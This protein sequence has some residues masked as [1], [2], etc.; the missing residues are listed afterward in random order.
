MNAQAESVNEFAVTLDRSELVK[1]LDIVSGALES[2]TTMPVLGCVCI[3]SD[4]ST[5]TLTVTDIEIFIRY[6]IAVNGPSLGVGSMVVEAKRLTD[7][8]KLLSTPSVT[9]KLLPNYY[10]NVTAGKSRTKIPGYQLSAFPEMPDP[11]VDKWVSVDPQEMALAIHMSLFACPKKDSVNYVNG[12]MISLEDRPHIV[13]LDGHRMS[14]RRFACEGGAG[15]FLMH[16]RALGEVKRLLD[17]CSGVDI[18]IAERYMRIRSEVF[19]VL[20]KRMENSYLDYMKIVELP[21]DKSCTVDGGELAGALRR[22]L[23]TAD[24]MFRGFQFNV[25]GEGLSVAS[26]DES[27][28]EQIAVI[29]FSGSTKSVRYNPNYLLEYLLATKAQK[30][31][32]YFGRGDTLLVKDSEDGSIY[33]M[34]SMR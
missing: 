6:K 12:G 30:V 21:F 16:R 4:G 2:R 14:Y 11:K 17:K 8:V 22:V 5:V 31:D 28:H 25:D 34:A 27:A 10:A 32:L 29:D 18:A 24:D 7:Y 1:A 33:T 15:K 19:D 26:L 13:C 20:V 3:E 9:L 23:S